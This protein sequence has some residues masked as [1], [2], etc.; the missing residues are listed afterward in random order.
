MWQSLDI[1][2]DAFPHSKKNTRVQLCKKILWAKLKIPSVVL[3]VLD[4]KQ[5]ERNEINCV[6]CAVNIGEI[7]NPHNKEFIIRREKHQSP[8]YW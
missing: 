6:S 7:S 1:W 2:Y 4:V 8:F 3:L 5:G